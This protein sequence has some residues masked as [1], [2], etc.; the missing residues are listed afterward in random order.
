MISETK[1]D[2]LFDT[3][4]FHVDGYTNYRRD[5]N[6]NGSGSLLYVRVDAPST[7][8]K[9]NPNFEAFY[10]VLN[11]VLLCCSYNPNKTLLKIILMKLVG[12]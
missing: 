3:P 4:Q 10:V 5:R 12:I 7:I 8:L 1:G 2:S 9:T 6:E 11:V